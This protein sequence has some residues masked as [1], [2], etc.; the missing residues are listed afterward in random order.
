M[1]KKFTLIIILFNLTA[2]SIG[3]RTITY[4]IASLTQ[5]HTVGI[6]SNP[7]Y[8]SGTLVTRIKTFITETL[9]RTHLKFFSYPFLDTQ[10][11]S[12]S[13]TRGYLDKDAL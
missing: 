5:D 2:C 9:Y 3:P 11:P 13:P 6:I 7:F 8:A 10:I 1:V 4:D 12:I